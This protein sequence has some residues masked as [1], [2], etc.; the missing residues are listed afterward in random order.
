[1]A[2]PSG[3]EPLGRVF[4]VGA[5]PGHPDLLTLRAVACLRRADVVVHD[6]LVPAALLD[7]VES[8]AERIP[9]PRIATA[10]DPG[11]S[12]GRLLAKLA[13]T[14]RSIVRLKGG[15]P[16]V[17][18]RLAE[19][20][21]PLREAGIP[22]EVVPGVT[23]ALAAAAA[24]G[25]PLTSR[26]AA[27]SVTILTGHEADEKTEALDFPALAGLPGTLAIYMGVEQV[28]KWSRALI[29]AGKPATT[30]VTVISRCSWPDQQI[31]VT[32][33]GDCGA[34]FERCRWPSPAVVIVGEVAD[35]PQPGSTEP[36]ALAGRRVLITRPRGQGDEL[37]ALIASL[38]GVCH[39]VPV[40]RIEPPESWE[41]LDQAIAAS[42]TFDWI[43]FASVNGA[44]SF[45]ERLRAAHRDGRHL[46][47]TRL[48]AIGSTTAR[49]LES[50]GLTCDLQPDRFQSEGVV[51]ALGATVRR[52]RFLLVRADRG[53]AV[54]RR[55]LE[56]LGH[57]VTEVASYS[58]R[59][60][61]SIDA[62]TLAAIDRGGIDW[63]TITSSFIAESAAR[64]FGDRM[65]QW[66]IASISPV[67][68]A[69]LLQQGL[70]PT[71]EARQP[72]AAA[73]A[74]AIAAWE[75]AQRTSTHAVKH[76]VDRFKCV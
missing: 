29:A 12:V 16:S 76:V 59:S 25:V 30:P 1:M 46:G 47:T 48:A 55:D 24:A 20:L 11:E 64:L 9:V 34:E 42:D 50:A 28:N 73:L 52:G 2:P 31:A 6:V 14:G 7:A 57:H 74:D 32:T 17:F 58:S 75:R 54:M 27:S 51:E 68:S 26:A 36:P 56:S 37:A 65:R 41:P 70:R 60:V 3:P 61:E 69:T 62:D 53:R 67:T 4:F 45:T 8:R 38:G 10:G 66:K 18:G 23:A 72:T 35:M 71:V 40:I 15:D 43:V 39:H 19:E 44:H 33:L 21:Q 22:F 49:A 13:T 63:I 5:G